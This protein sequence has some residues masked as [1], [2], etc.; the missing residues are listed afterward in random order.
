MENIPTGVAH[1]GERETYS[2]IGSDKVEGTRVYATDGDHIGHI[3]RVMIGKLDGHVAYAVL[4][5]G[6]FLGIGQDYYP[7][8][9]SSL[10]FNPA[11][12]G[13]EVAVTEDQLRG[14]PRYAEDA[15]WNWEDRAVAARVDD[16]WRAYS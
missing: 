1:T 12:G 7:L 4:A 2:L 15:E 16:Y 11:L 8:P 10:T 9:W 13:Y 3:E 5:F 14:A 6:G